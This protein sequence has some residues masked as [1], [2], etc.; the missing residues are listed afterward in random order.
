LLSSTNI[1]VVMIGGDSRIRR[2]TQ[3]ARTLM[4]L[5]PTDVGRPV[6][7]LRPAMHV[8]DFQRM[9]DQVLKTAQPVECEV[10]AA[11]GMWFVMRVTPYHT[12]D[13]KI[14]GAVVVLV[15]IEQIKLAER[16]LREVD[17]RKDEFLATLAHEL[18]NPIAPI[19]NALEILDLCE[20]EPE[21]TR[22]ARDVL[23]RQVR[24]LSRIVDDLIDVSRIVERKI[25]LRPARIALSDVVDM[26]VETTRTFIEACRHRLIVSLPP[27]PVYLDADLG[28]LAQVI[29]NLLNNA[30]KYMKPGGKIWLAAET[31]RNVEKSAEGPEEVRISVRDTGIGIEPELLP[32]IFDMFTQG[33]NDIEHGRGGLGIGLTLAKSLVEMH[34]GRLTASSAGRDHGTEFVI[35]LPVARLEPVAAE[36]ERG[37]EPRAARAAHPRRILVVDDN[38]DQVE[39]MRLLLGLH[40]HEVEIARDGP[41]ALAAIDRRPPEFALVDIGLPGMTGYELARLI[42]ERPNGNAVTIVAQTGWGQDHDRARAEQAG[43]DHHLVKP[44]DIRRLEEIL[45]GPLRVAGNEPA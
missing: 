28:R 37:A 36:P 39:S 40:G 7:D 31:V 8:P 17:R 22:L 21:A 25:E 14:D 35:T 20:G 3:S 23:K 12:A 32:R 5:L 11:G 33:S 10:Q 41:S 42:R 18:R 26:A 6:S 29:V 4:N 2:F 30:A 9:I 43:F 34:G 13:G 27:R 45:A 44:I 24:Q 15:D 38:P 16:R 1:P 19:R